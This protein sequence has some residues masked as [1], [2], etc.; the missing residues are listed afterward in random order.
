MVSCCQPAAGLDGGFAP[1]AAGAGEVEEPPGGGASAVLDQMMAVEHQRLGLG[2]E[3]VGAVQV[4]PAC[5]DHADLRIGDEVRNDLEQ[6]VGLGKKV[7]VEH[8]DEVALGHFETRV[9]GAGLEAGAIGAMHVGDFEVRL[10]VAKLGDVG[11]GEGFGF[12]GRVVEDLNLERA[13]RIANGRDV[14]EQTGDDGGFV[15]DG[16]LNRHVRE[17]SAVDR[18]GFGDVRRR[19]RRQSVAHLLQPTAVAEARED[20]MR[21][22]D[23]VHRQEQQHGEIGRA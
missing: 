6:K 5:L 3:R 22:V 7:G 11:A 16:Q 1:D 19:Q 18:G 13:A 23:A 21:P 14:V 2:Q 15:E 8:G 20:Q 17:R 12:V 4:P 10:G 9:E